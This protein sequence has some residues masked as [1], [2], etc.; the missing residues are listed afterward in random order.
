VSL[1]DENEDGTIGPDI[2]KVRAY[3]GNMQHTKEAEQVCAAAQLQIPTR[4]DGLIH[5]LSVPHTSFCLKMNLVR[6]F[7]YGAMEASNQL[8]LQRLTRMLLYYRGNA[9]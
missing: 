9:S 1:L 8:R 4:V 6:L 2:L 7:I 3:S 5:S